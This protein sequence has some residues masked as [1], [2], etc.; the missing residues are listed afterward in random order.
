MPYI[1]IDTDDFHDELN[2]CKTIEGQVSINPLVCLI[3]SNIKDNNFGVGYFD[4]I[5]FNSINKK[6]INT[7][8]NTS[9]KYDSRGNLINTEIK[10]AYTD[11]GTRSANYLSTSTPKTK[12]R[13]MHILINIDH[14]INI[15]RE[16]RNKDQKS[17]VYYS[18]FLN[19]LLSDISKSLCSLNDFRLLVDDSSKS[20]KII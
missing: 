18:D 12:A 4:D 9:P 16:L 13:L 7:L 1:D 3:P 20:L 19:Q 5:I 8:E 15:L 10:R 11:N 6:G 2:Y 17:N 14:I